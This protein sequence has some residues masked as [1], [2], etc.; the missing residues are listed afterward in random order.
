MD[1]DGHGVPTRLVHCVDPD[2]VRAEVEG[3]RE[4]VRVDATH[5]VAL[6]DPALVA[7][8]IER[9]LAGR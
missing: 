7:G 9:Y 1:V 3:P 4:V 5:A 8:L 6:E 2:E